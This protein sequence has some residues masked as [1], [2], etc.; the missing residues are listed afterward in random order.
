M[1]R[2]LKK[3]KPTTPKFSAC[4]STRIWAPPY[5]STAATAIWPSSTMAPTVRWP[6]DSAFPSIC[7]Q[8]KMSTVCMRRSRLC[9]SSASRA[10]R[11]SIPASRSIPS[12]SPI[13]TAIHWSIRSLWTKA[14]TALCILFPSANN[15]VLITRGCFYI[16]ICRIVFKIPYRPRIRLL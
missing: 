11:R 3:Q 13:P 1:A 10:H 4:P 14:H 16:R 9:R 12:S 6:P 5:G 7:P 15:P 8:P 2:I